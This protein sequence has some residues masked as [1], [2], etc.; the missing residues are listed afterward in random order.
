MHI[1]KATEVTDELFSALQHLIPQLGAHKIPP[2]RDELSA[3]VHSESS[4]LLLARQPDAAGAIVGTLSLILYRVPTGI[5]SIIE[6]IVVD[7][8]YR[9]RGMA[10]SLLG[11]A[12]H[13]A[14]EAGAGNISLTSI[15][16][17]EEANLLYQK[18]GFQIRVTNP[19]FYRLK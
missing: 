9:R 4:M 6:D 18:M 5:R 19:Y 3:L 8:K 13:L 2:T 15:A 12:I 11:Y 17:R 14:R 7:E 1:E 10:Q 16:Q